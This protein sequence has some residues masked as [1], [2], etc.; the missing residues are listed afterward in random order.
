MDSNQPPKDIYGI[1][2]ARGFSGLREWKVYV[3]PDYF[4]TNPP[5]VRIP[6]GR[7]LEALV[8]LQ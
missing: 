2:M 8:R 1:A 4:L 3:F 5:Y 6:M 7:N